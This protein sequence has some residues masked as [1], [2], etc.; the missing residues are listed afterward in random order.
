[1]ALLSLNLNF[2]PGVC[3]KDAFLDGFTR[4]IDDQHLEL[5]AQASESFRL[6][7]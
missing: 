6:I 5:E 7:F 3:I 1:M 4:F 2:G